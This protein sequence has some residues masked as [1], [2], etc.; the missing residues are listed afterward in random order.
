LW[1]AERALGP[2]EAGGGPGEPGTGL[3]GFP[4]SPVFAPSASRRRGAVFVYCR[5]ERGALCIFLGHPVLVLLALSPVIRAAARPCC[6]CL[7][8]PRSS[9]WWGSPFQCGSGLVPAVPVYSRSRDG[10]F[11]TSVT[12]RL[13]VGVRSGNG[14]A[15]QRV[16]FCRQQGG[17]SRKRGAQRPHPRARHCTASVLGLVR[18][19]CRTALAQTRRAH[20]FRPSAG[21]AFDQPTVEA[22]LGTGSS[23]SCVRL[24]FSCAGGAMPRSM[25]GLLAA[26]GAIMS[27]LVSVVHGGL[28]W[29][30]AAAI[31][32]IVGVVA[33]VTAP[34]RPAL[35][36]ALKKKSLV[37]PI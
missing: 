11:P 19:I 24:A 5:A 35:A 32:L 18:E 10:V 29:V 20:Q 7:H 4:G 16:R 25:V 6:F 15:T 12:A 21:S 3:W 1:C 30:L 22:R 9:V 13:G 34:R 28:V 8:F 36:I 17:S 31:G 26:V 14:D 33:Y 2:G 23:L 27:A 37:V